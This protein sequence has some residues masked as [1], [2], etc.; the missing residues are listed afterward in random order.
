[1]AVIVPAVSVAVLVSDTAAVIIAVCDEV[2]DV[3]VKL[4]VVVLFTAV[5]VALLKAWVRTVAPVW[6]TL[7]K[8]SVTPLGTL[9]N[10][11][12]T[13]TPVVRAVTLFETCVFVRKAV[14]KP[15]AKMIDAVL[16]TMFLFVKT[17]A[18]PS[19]VTKVKGF[20]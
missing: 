7:A 13:W 9:L 20:T 1:V 5:I 17:V 10:V 15:S 11:N 8:V 19:V 3:A 14:A 6:L 2:N 12:L 4:R 16:S 18:V